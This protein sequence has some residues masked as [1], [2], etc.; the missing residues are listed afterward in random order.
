[1][2]VRVKIQRFDPEEDT[3]PHFREYTVSGKK[4]D[5]VL[6]L[7]MRIKRHQDGT[8]ALRQ[9]CAHG[10]CGSDAMRINGTERLACKTLVQDVLDE[11]SEVITVE[12]LQNLPV[13]KDLMVDQEEFFNRYRSVKPFLITDE[14][15]PEREWLQSQEERKP[16]DDATKCILCA[17]CYSGIRIPVFSGLHRSFRPSGSTT[18]AGTAVSS[19][20]SKPSTHRTA[21]GPAKIIFSAPGYAHAASR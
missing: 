5:R 17:S 1:M 14:P 12:P 4:T 3:K 13:Q 10:V 21:S 7:L 11:D 20:G 2:K 15:T 16:I 8:L 9:S 6:D 19:S 18:T